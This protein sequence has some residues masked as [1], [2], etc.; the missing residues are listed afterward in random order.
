MTV[1]SKDYIARLEIKLATMPD[2]ELNLISIFLKNELQ[3]RS[4][5]NQAIEY[6]KWNRIS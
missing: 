6:R 3:R 4:I 5:R 1:V 2:E